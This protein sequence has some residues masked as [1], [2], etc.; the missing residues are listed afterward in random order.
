MNLPVEVVESVREGK[1]LLFVGSRAS[2]E[3]AEAA[4]QEYPDEKGL[5]RAL[6]GRRCSLEEALASTE[7][8]KGRVGLQQALRQAT[9]VAGVPPSVFHTA[10]IRRFPVV[11]TSTTDDLLERAALA[12][13]A[14]ADVYWRGDDLPTPDLMKR[15]VYKYWGDFARPDS[16]ALTAEDRRRLAQSEAIR[17]EWRFLLRG[18]VLFFVGYD[19]SSDELEAVWEDVSAAYGGELPRCHLAV[20]QGKFTDRHWQK[21]VWR[22]VLL[23]PADPTDVAEALEQHLA[24]GA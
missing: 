9:D 2:A 20:P 16:L 6:T 12:L 7:R 3:A 17:R 14:P 10:A 8:E 1:C 22:G 11:F 19:I 5:A 21:W 4:G 18:H 15:A 24:A 23:F 13:G